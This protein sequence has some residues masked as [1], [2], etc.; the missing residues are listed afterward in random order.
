MTL[1]ELRDALGISQKELDRMA[2]LPINTVHLIESGTNKNPGIK[3]CVAI[4]EALREAGAKGVTVEDI[5]AT[6][7]VGKG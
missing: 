2:G 7:P 3:T 6:Q 1:G 4:T 5:F